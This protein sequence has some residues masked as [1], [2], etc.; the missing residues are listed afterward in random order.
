MSQKAC[1][2]SMLLMRGRQK[3][4]LLFWKQCSSMQ[5]AK[6]ILGTSGASVNVF[7]ILLRNSKGN[8][9]VAE[10]SRTY[11]I[12]SKD[13]EGKCC[14]LSLPAIS[15]DPYWL[16]IRARSYFWLRCFATNTVVQIPRCFCKICESWLIFWKN[17]FQI[18]SGRKA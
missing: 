1:I 3:M 9:L 13:K 5:A 16:C 15:F 11:V 7:V 12:A 8:D 10:C 2:L 17:F 18:D 6:C 14:V 4:T